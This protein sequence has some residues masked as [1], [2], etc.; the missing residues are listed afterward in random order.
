MVTSSSDPDLLA[1]VQDDV[2]DRVDSAEH[3]VRNGEFEA[4]ESS[5]LTDPLALPMWSLSLLFLTLLYEFSRALFLSWSMMAWIWPLSG[6]LLLYPLF[7]G[8]YL[9]YLTRGSVRRRNWAVCVFPPLRMA[10]RDP[11]TGTLLY[12]P[13]FGWQRANADLARRIEETVTLILLGATLILGS[14]VFVAYYRTGELSAIDDTWPVQGIALLIWLLV[15]TELILE[16]SL[17]RHRARYFQSRRVNLV[18]AVTP[19]LPLL[20][21][22]LLIRV[23]RGLS[24]IE[25]VQRFFYRSSQARIAALEKQIVIHEEELDELRDKLRAERVRQISKTQRTSDL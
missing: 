22:A 15:V 17:V 12:L 11:E 18:V 24:R 16:L 5:E 10:C 13:G 20:R 19:M 1:A 14:Y 7:I 4:T 9:F 21:L 6:M 8:E 25:S 23:V 2:I 3:G